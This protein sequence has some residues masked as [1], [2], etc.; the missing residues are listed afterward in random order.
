MIDVLWNTIL[1][2]SRDATVQ[3]SLEWRNLISDVYGLKSD[4]QVLSGFSNPVLLTLFECRK[5][6]KNK[7]TNM[8]YIMCP[9]PLMKGNCDDIVLEYLKSRS[10]DESVSFELKLPYRLDEELRVSY[11]LEEHSVVLNSS[12]LLKG[13]YEEQE[14]LFSKNLKLNLRRRANKAKR[15]D[16]RIEQSGDVADVEEFYD[17]LARLYRDVH[18]MPFHPKKL[19]LG[20]VD[21]MEGMSRFVVARL[22]GRIIAGSLLLYNSNVAQY[23]WGASDRNYASY[24]I[25]SLL[26]KDQIEFAISNNCR[27]FH[28]GSSGNFQEGLLRYKKEWGA[29]HTPLYLYSY[30]SHGKPP[31]LQE[32]FRVARSVYRR[33]PICLLKKM[34]PLIVPYMA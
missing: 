16:V 20:I 2:D 26:L 30:N 5:I 15:N 25:D 22:G 17:L 18:R 32:S 27:E 9:S 1:A 7:L 4:Y 12:F 3:H 14:L 34:M 8:P 13:S 10:L 23:A 28:L 6:G 31:N 11:E 33:I 29:N 21:K 24:G 19:F